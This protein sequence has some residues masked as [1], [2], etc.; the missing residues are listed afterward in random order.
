M[1]GKP[2][3]HADAAV[4]TARARLL[5]TQPM[6]ENSADLDLIEYGI[7][8]GIQVT[9]DLAAEAAAAAYE[10]LTARPEEDAT[11]G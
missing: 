9:L 6:R 7:G 8:L 1:T 4:L 10:A 11:D 3:Q 5:I 2:L